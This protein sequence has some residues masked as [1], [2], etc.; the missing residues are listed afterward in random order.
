MLESVLPSFSGVLFAFATVRDARYQGENGKVV[1]WTSG[2]YVRFS[3]AVV[4][5]EIAHF[6]KLVRP[7]RSRLF[8]FAEIKCHLAVVHVAEM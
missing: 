6:L 1:R 3:I 8:R 7:L 4:G 2:L 5:D